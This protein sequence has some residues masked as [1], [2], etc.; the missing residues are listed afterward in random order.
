MGAPGAVLGRPHPAK[1]AGDIFL[2]QLRY[3]T[4]LTSIMLLTSPRM[5]G[6]R[7]WRPGGLASSGGI[8]DASR[9]L[10]PLHPSL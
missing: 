9:L 8:A 10:A 7:G 4:R 2:S 6:P 1:E 5:S 3:I